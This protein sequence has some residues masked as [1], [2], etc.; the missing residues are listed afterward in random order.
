MIVNS[1]VKTNEEDISDSANKGS[2]IRF[3]N[4]KNISNS[5]DGTNL[6]QHVPA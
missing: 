1:S 3:Y 4:Q 5:T 2:G 6:P